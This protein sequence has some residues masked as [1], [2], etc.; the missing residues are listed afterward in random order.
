MPEY[1]KKR[2]LD[3][4]SIQDL[5]HHAGRIPLGGMG[6]HVQEP[7]GY[8]ILRVQISYVPSYNEE[9][10]AL[11]VEDDSAFISK[12]PVVLGTPTINRA[13]RAM[14]ESELEEAPESWQHARYA[15]EYASYIA[16]LDTEQFDTQMPTNTGENPRDIDEKLFLKKKM[17]IPAFESAILHCRTKKFQMLGCRL[18][19]MT[20]A[21]YQE[22]EAHLPNGVYVLK[23]YTDLLPGSQS[24]SVVLR[25]L[26]GKPVHLAAGRCVA[27]VVAANMIPEAKPSA[28][29]MKKLEELEPSPDQKKL[30]IPERQALLMELLKKD[31]R[32]DKLKE[33]TPDLA[34]E[35]ER[36]L[37]EHHGIFSLDK[38]EIGCTDTAEHVIEL[39]DTEPF[40]E[41]FRRIAPPLVEE[42]REHIQEMLDRGAIC[43]SQSPW[44]NAV[45]LVCK[46]D[47]GLRF[48]IDF[49][50]LNRRTKKDAFPLPRMQETME[51]MVG[52]RLFSTMDL[53]SGFWQVKMAK[54]SQ[55]YTA[56]TVGSMGV[57]EFL[58]MPYGLCNAPATFQR[59]MQ[60]CLGE[61][62]L[63]YALIYLD[64]VIVFSSTEED[65]IHRLRIVFSRFMEHGLKLK[66]SKC[67]FLQDEITFLGHQISAE[68]MKPGT[69]N[70][71]AIAEMAPP[72]TYTGIREYTGMTGF[73]RWF[74]K[75]YAKIEKPL[76]DLLSGEASKL[77]SEPVQL[78]PEALQAFEELKLKYMTAPVLAFADF[79][80]EF[81][82][83]TDASS[84]GLGAVL[85]QQD[86]AL[87]GFNMKLDYVKGTDNKVA[88]ALSRV[89]QRLDKETVTE[90]LNCARIGNM[91]RAESDNINVIQEGEWVDQEIIVRHTHI[92]KQHKKFRNLAN[93][94]WVAAQNRDPV[95]PLVKEWVDRP[96]DDTRKL[97]EFLGKR[98]PEYDRRFY[99]AR[100]KEFMIHDDLL[101]LRITTPTGQD[102]TQVFVVPAGKRQAAIDR[103]HRSA[104]HQGRDRTLSLLKERF[105]WP[106]M[107]RALFRAVSTCGRC[108]QYEAKGQLPPMNPILCTEPMELVHIDYVGMEVT[109]AAKEKPVVKN[110]LVVVDHFTHYVQAYVTKNHTA[111]TTARVLYNNYFSVFGFPQRL[112]SDQGT[113]FCRNVISA[114]CS[115]LGVEKIRMTPYHLQTNGSAERVHHT[116]Q[117][118]IGKLDPEKRKKWPYHIGSILIAY[119]A[120]RSMVTGFSPYFLMFGRRPRLP[121]D[122][123]FPTH[124][125]QGLT[126]TIDEYVANLYDRLRD[127]LMKG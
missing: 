73:F 75:G 30:T 85:L 21:I 9:Q 63:T 34:L 39:L 124:R 51:S 125:A 13:V 35:F 50:R 94:G 19:A 84:D 113:E 88:D 4:G 67:H 90:L 36:M 12:C 44:C 14:K 10:V 49:R 110:V 83:E 48:C 98:V 59:L 69:E 70:L 42:V 1:V 71:R 91:P 107:S 57:Y 43:P 17:T 118:M 65:H 97:E 106:G 47:G 126:R 120:T 122:L 115:L 105:W 27:R 52:A 77:K 32:L 15:Y 112:M 61:L 45:V 114:M 24:V 80:K 25:N 79:E 64:D 89:R 40:K 3:M 8:V 103:C 99:A 23:T 60:N 81:H 29:F 101:Y 22:D 55:Q 96:K 82:L 26:T 31:G 87:A 18:H 102:S 62:N 56:F 58:R 20:Q 28:N 66:P 72:T 16:Q 54:E 123:L 11:V 7:L 108:K 95:I 41:R 121:I 127:S 37:L 74:I 33:W 5:N 116:L 119:N 100:Q 53:K 92:V 104:R 38:N 2:E 78:T 46:K 117:R 68:G 93:G 111:R 86:N 76:N 109:V 6:G